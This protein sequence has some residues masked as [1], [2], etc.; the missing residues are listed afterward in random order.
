MERT[1]STVCK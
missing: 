1:F